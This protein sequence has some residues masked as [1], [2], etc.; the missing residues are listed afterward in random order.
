MHPKAQVPLFF[1][2]SGQLLG[3]ISQKRFYENPVRVSRNYFERHTR[4]SGMFIKN[5][6]SEVG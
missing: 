4:C 6:L 1:C 3:S 5:L 2:S